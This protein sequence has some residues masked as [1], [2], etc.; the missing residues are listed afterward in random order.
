MAALEAL[1]TVGARGCFF[2]DE[3]RLV[4]GGSQTPG[5][6][7]LW[8]LETRSPALLPPLT[9]FVCWPRLSLSE[10]ATLAG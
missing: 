8:K 3:A 9:C 7:R 4:L 10:L 1:L 2:S 6:T 5:E